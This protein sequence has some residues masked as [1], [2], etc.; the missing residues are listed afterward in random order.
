MLESEPDLAAGN[1]M[2]PAEPISVPGRLQVVPET[3][4]LGAVL[5]VE[6]ERSVVVR[7]CASGRAARRAITPHTGALV[8][9]VQ[10]LAIDGQLRLALQVYSQVQPPPCAMLQPMPA[11]SRAA[12]QQDR[13]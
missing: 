7:S 6:L 10:T 12:T 2:R 3:E 5:T 4:D 13:S 1:D 8:A 11:C 9:L